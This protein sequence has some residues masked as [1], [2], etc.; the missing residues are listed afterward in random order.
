MLLSELETVGLKRCRTCKGKM[1]RST[2]QSD[3][4]Q[5]I[6]HFISPAADVHLW[7]YVRIKL[8]WL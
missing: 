2:I 4:R 5:H 1:L 8:G 6:G 7:E 3:L